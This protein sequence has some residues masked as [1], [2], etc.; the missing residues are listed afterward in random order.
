MWTNITKSYCPNDILAAIGAF[1][2]FFFFFFF[3][4]RGKRGFIMIITVL[5]L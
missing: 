2:F 4:K 3:F 1:F 5:I